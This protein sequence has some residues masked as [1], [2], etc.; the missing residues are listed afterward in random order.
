MTHDTQ[1][2]D[3]LRALRAWREKEEREWQLLKRW[4][5]WLTAAL[6]VGLAVEAFVVFVIGGAP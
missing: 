1:T 2:P 5:A 4:A 3:P 6:L